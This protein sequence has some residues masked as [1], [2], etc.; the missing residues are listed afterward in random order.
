MLPLGAHGNSEMDRTLISCVPILN[1]KPNPDV[2]RVSMITTIYPDCTTSFLALQTRLTSHPSPLL[3]ALLRDTL[4]ML[5]A[6]TALL[7]L[8]IAS[9]SQS[10]HPLP[11]L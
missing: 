3:L 7:L 5:L 11:A 6:M 4:A 9:A 2:S 8:L 1:F 10:C